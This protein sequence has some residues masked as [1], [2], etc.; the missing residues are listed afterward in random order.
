MRGARCF[1]QGGNDGNERGRTLIASSCKKKTM[2]D[3]STCPTNPYMY[4]RWKMG[5]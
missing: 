4:I 1:N 2:H 3:V 5:E